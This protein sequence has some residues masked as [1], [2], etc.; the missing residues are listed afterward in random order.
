MQEKIAKIKSQGNATVEISLNDSLGQVFWKKKHLDRVWGIRGGVCMSQVF[1]LP[2]PW[3]CVTST[4]MNI[5]VQSSAQELKVHELRSELKTKD[6]NIKT[7]TMLLTNSSMSI[8][9]NFLMFLYVSFIIS[10]G[11]L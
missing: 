11:L 4:S 2:N 1:G 10:L 9:L 3:L 7:M 5:G 8:L 6:A